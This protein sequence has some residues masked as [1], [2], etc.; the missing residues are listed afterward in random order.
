MHETINLLGAIDTRLKRHSLHN[1]PKNKKHQKFTFAKI[2]DFSEDK[3]N[4][5]PKFLTEREDFL[6]FMY[7]KYETMLLSIPKICEKE[8]KESDEKYFISLFLEQIPIFKGLPQLIKEILLNSVR[9]QY[10]QP[11]AIIHNEDNHM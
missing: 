1:T 2:L 6:Q 10:Y 5:Y 11:N 9:T 3:F 7:S 4:D 8:H